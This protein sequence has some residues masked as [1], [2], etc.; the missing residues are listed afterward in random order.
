MAL[1]SY[2]KQ[3][4]DTLFF[5]GPG[6]IIYYVPEKYFSLRVATINGEYVELMGIFRYCLFD[7]NN[8]KVKIKDFKCPTMIKCKPSLIE[9]VNNYELEGT[10]EPSNYRLLRFKNNDELI[11]NLSVPQDTGNVEKFVKLLTKANL[12]KYIPYE[13]LYEYMIMN[14]E[15]NGFNYKVSNQIIGILISE[16]CRDPK[17]LTKP[18]RYTD[19]KEPYKMIPIT[20]VPKYISP[21]T[22]I[23]SENPDEAI[24]G[25]LTTT[26]SNRSPLEKVMMN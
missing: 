19:M 14:A 12:P 24:A 10:S 23:T 9:R 8:K 4:N 20:Q 13:E 21:Y 17:D 16:L 6:E 22:A 11:S 2:M 5:N 26:G 25:A 18:Y 1:P 3:I 7:E 15:M